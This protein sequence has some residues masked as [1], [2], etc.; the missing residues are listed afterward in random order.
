M[1]G[2]FFSSALKFLLGNSNEQAFYWSHEDNSLLACVLASVQ[3]S[4]LTSC[5]WHTVTSNNTV[6]VIKFSEALLYQGSTVVLGG[7]SPE[8]KIFDKYT[9]DLKSYSSAKMPAVQ[10]CLIWQCDHGDMSLTPK[11]VSEGEFPL[12]RWLSQM[13]RNLAFIWTFSMSSRIAIKRQ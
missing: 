8:F 4:L 3:I 10:C 2:H 9:S 6:Q 11:V 12:C 7:T 13:R 1:W 5:L